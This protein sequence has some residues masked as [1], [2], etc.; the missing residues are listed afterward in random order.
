MPT[1]F[2][3]DRAIYEQVIEDM[4][5]SA[6][7]FVWIGTAL[8]K[9]LH[10]KR[11]R[12]MVPFLSVLADMLDRGVSVRLLHASEPGPRFRK[13]FDR[14]PA[15]IEGLERML[16]PRVHFKSV[17]VDGAKAYSGSA[18]FTGAGMGAKSVR[19]RNFEA[20]FVTDDKKLVGQIMD[21]FDQVWMGA[22]CGDCGR[23]SYCPD[24][25]LND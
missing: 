22:H 12:R 5:V 18:N 11:E 21:Q 2:I 7:Q 4:V 3:T 25:P 24:C 19:N 16:C 1:A 14:Y 15:L 10:V 13:D 6:E 17:I 20:G 9:D 8:V 23:K